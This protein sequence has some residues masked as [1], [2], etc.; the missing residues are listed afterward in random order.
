[1]LQVPFTLAL[2]KCPTSNLDPVYTTEKEHNS[3]VLH[4]VTWSGASLGMVRLSLVSLKSET[5]PFVFQ[6]CLFSVVE[7]FG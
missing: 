2:L 1:M 3:F 7:L 6:L 5:L 4:Q